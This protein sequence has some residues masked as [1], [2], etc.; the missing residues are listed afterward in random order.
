MGKNKRQKSMEIEISGCGMTITG[1]GVFI[2]QTAWEAIQAHSEHLF[3]LDTQ[4]LKGDPNS[5]HYHTMT[6]KAN[7]Y[8]LYQ[9]VQDA[10]IVKHW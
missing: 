4:D 5:V 2:T 8:N 6:V 3:R 10:E 9:A 7:K 1:D